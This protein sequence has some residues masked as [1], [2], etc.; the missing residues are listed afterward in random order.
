[1]CQSRFG[2]TN[3]SRQWRK[4]PARKKSPNRFEINHLIRQPGNPRQ[5]VV[6]RGIRPTSGESSGTRKEPPDE[7]EPLRL[8]N[9]PESHS[10]CAHRASANAFATWWKAAIVSRAGWRPAADCPPSLSWAGVQSGSK[11]LTTESSDSGHCKDDAWVAPS[12]GSRVDALSC[13]CRHA[14]G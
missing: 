3:C 9:E 11:A 12:R 4:P 13:R 14:A 1:M 8:G 10:F 2:S 6:M 7:R 5:A